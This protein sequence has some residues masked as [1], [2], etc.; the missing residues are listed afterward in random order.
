MKFYNDATTVVDEALN[1][2]INTNPMLSLLR[3]HRVIYRSDIAAVRDHE[4]TLISG[5][6]SGHEPSHAGFVGDGMLSAAV[7]GDVFASPSASQVIAAIKTVRSNKGILLIVKNYTGDR[8][9]FGKAA[10]RA[11]KDLNIEIKLL[12]IGDDA[13]I[14]KEKV[15]SV[16]RRGLAGILLCHKILGAMAKKGCSLEEI[17]F[18]GEMI[19][20]NLGT[21]GVATSPCTLFGKT[22]VLFTDANVMEIGLGYDVL[23]DVNIIL[24]SIHGEAGFQKSAMSSS[25]KVVKT[26]L[27]ML[28][29]NPMELAEF[30]D[31]FSNYFK[32]KISNADKVCLIINNLNSCTSLELGILIN[33]TI[34]ELKSRGIETLRIFSGPLMVNVIKIHINSCVKTSLEMTGFSITILKLQ[35]EDWLSY[36]D[37]QVRV[38]SWPFSQITAES[39][40]ISSKNR[41]KN[42]ENETD[43]VKMLDIV[44]KNGKLFAKSLYLGCQ[45][46]IKASPKITELDKIAG[47][48]DCG[49]SLSQGASSILNKISVDLN[50]DPKSSEF[51]F[52][53]F[54][55]ALSSISLVLEDN[56][57]GTSGAVYCLFLDAAAQCISEIDTEDTLAIW[58]KAF[59]G[60]CTLV[61]SLYPAIQSFQSGV[62]K[63][64]DLQEILKECVKSAKEGVEHTRLM[65]SA[66]MGRAAYQPEGS[67]EGIPDPG[68]FG[69]AVL[70]EEMTT[71][72][73]I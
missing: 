2:L 27:D 57:G 34:L 47:D 14:P 29:H 35:N 5:G 65:K 31:M 62:S 13:A 18:Q 33:D 51:A 17:F 41:T 66:S 59:M 9:Q 11:K 73:S 1:G 45:A 20:K 7:C 8:L 56:M 30:S 4:V 52:D 60:D 40:K 25:K 26:V 64:M 19:A 36:L 50:G 58:A 43:K 53:N 48:G 10:I 23:I 22:P 6:G 38:L 67:L 68:A 16:G 72:F 46:L 32:L 42:E 28:I 54:S 55:D 69:V 44:T 63:N 21:I 3:K 39:W 70:I 61:D 15:K 37:Y 71:I 24:I 12:V 49:E